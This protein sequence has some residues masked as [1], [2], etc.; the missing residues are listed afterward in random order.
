M[1]Y[2]YEVA[3]GSVGS[4]LYDSG[5]NMMYVKVAFGKMVRYR[6]VIKRRGSLHVAIGHRCARNLMYIALGWWSGA[7]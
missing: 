7:T 1:A 2:K 3:V 6:L 4:K 5:E